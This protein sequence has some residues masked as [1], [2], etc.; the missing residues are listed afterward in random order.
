[1]SDPQTTAQAPDGSAAG[2]LPM[3][4]PLLILLSAT[5]A[6]SPFALIV[7][8]PALGAL[9]QQYAVGSGNIQFLISAYV[10]GIAC[11]QP[12][13]G[14]L[15]DRLGRRP[16]LLGGFACLVI[17]SIVC[18]FVE[19]LDVL[20]ALRFL[21]GAG[22][23][24]G[25]V[26]SRAVVRD[27][28]DDANAA[29]A[30]SYIA[31]FM[32]LAP[33]LAPAVG[34]IVSASYGPQSVFLLSAAL[35]AVIWTWALVKYPETA[36]PRGHDHPTLHQWFD[37]Y[38]QLVR[39]RV[40]VGYSLMYGLAQAVFLTFMTVGA[41]V[42]AHDLGRDSTYFGITWG[43][44]AIAYV[45][46][47][48][49]CG[50]LTM[51]F[52]QRRLLRFGLTTLLIGGWLLLALIAVFGVTFWTLIAPLLIL[53]L[54]NGIVTPLSLAGAISYRPMIAGSSSGLSSA[55]GLSLSGV[56][57]IIAGAVYVDSF[58]PVAVIMTGLATLAAATGWL[59]RGE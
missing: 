12:V 1:M 27:M 25:T 38:K 51:S 53:S 31:A 21:Q 7:L 14:I 16:V 30:M 5:S 29:R 20:I 3:D 33:I 2:S 48:M 42:F 43:S 52:G 17:A 15:C 47:A 41:A 6:V 18:A 28:H 56:F 34:G 39:S 55:I 23:S 10:L 22:A 50:K 35:G 58:W 36:D 32:G 4:A 26:T 9:A 19:R 49:I 54:A 37:S 40:F 8:A 24:V 46:G 11:A 44:L 59:T 57:T 45:S 13:S